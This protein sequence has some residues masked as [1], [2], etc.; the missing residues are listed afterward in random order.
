MY[1]DSDSV[2]GGRHYLRTDGGL[3]VGYVELEY[4]YSMSRDIRRKAT[5]WVYS[6]NLTNEFVWGIA[7]EEEAKALCVLAVAGL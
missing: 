1:W 7:T 4:S 2:S 3:A 6:I 5:P